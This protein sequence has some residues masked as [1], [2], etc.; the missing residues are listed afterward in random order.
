MS[1][2]A[3]VSN[4]GERYGHHHGKWVTK[5]RLAVVE[6]RA[7]FHVFD[8]GRNVDVGRNIPAAASDVMSYAGG[9]KSIGN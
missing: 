4:G 7:A 9:G 2:N 5:K 1:E 8:V 6:Q 3:P